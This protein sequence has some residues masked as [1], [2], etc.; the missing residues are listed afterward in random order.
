M[1]NKRTLYLDPDKWDITLNKNGDIITASHLYADAQNVA[2]A[3]R[4]FTKDAFL[5][6]N[7]GVPHFDLDLARMPAFSAVRAVYRKNAR[8]V[9]NIRDAFINNL[10]VDNDT[11]TLN[12]VI[13]ATTE[14]GQN[15][16][17]EI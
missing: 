6:Q 5:A 9:E 11:R 8:A 15:V 2:N 17:V 16:S 10:R 3:I 12:G 4:L 7:K 1:A 13:I 14:D